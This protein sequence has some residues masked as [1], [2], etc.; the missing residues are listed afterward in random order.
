[1][2]THLMHR[3]AGSSGVLI[4]FQLES[5]TSTKLERLLQER[6]WSGIGA[7]VFENNQ[8]SMDQLM[9]LVEAM[10]SLSES[11]SSY[12][13]ESQK[14]LLEALLYELCAFGTDHKAEPINS[15]FYFFQQLVDEHF[16]TAHSVGFYLDKLPIG[17]KRLATLSKSHMGVSP[18]QVIHRRLLL[19]AKRS[20]LLGD[21][22]HKEI[23]FD[24]GFD[25]PAS[26][27]AFIKKKTGL[28][29]SEIQA[30]VTEI[31]K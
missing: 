17:E 15:D 18:L 22:A 13:K 12:W 27:S 16:R 11:R 8:G 2:Q 1:G 23:A 24:L 3:E 4:Q 29:A 14:S 6:A 25:S 21:Q 30:Q 19:E 20:L 7:V 10:K 26:F 31:H 28:T 9:I 5:I